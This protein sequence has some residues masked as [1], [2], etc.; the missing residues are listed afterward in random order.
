M[1]PGGLVKRSHP[2]P[3][4]EDRTGL[5]HR[6]LVEAVMSGAAYGR[7]CRAHG[8][9]CRVTGRLLVRCPRGHVL[10]DDQEWDVVPVPAAAWDVLAEYHQFLDLVSWAHPAIQGERFWE[11]T[12]ALVAAPPAQIRPFP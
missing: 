5:D 2:M 9:L 6:G 4:L 10:A 3:C 7:R 11:L 12:A 1:Q 8:L